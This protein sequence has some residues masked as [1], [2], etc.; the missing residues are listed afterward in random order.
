MNLE[1]FK[2]GWKQTEVEKKVSHLKN[3]ANNNTLLVQEFQ[4]RYQKESIRRDMYT[5]KLE[6]TVEQIF[7]AIS[8][9]PEIQREILA[10]INFLQEF[11]DLR[12]V[13]TRFADGIK[14][15][16]YD[17]GRRDFASGEP[18]NLVNN[19]KKLVKTANIKSFGGH[20]RT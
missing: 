1:N 7:R 16:F 14:F 11:N 6:P 4:N 18:F 13:I 9:V 3:V 12:N 17:N 10:E 19:N 2:Q 15:V 5:G 20:E 8:K